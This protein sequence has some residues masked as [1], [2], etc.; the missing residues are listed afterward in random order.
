MKN[1]NKFTVFSVQEVINGLY[2]GNNSAFARANGVSRQAVQ[3]WI[4]D[5][6][7]IGNGYLYSPKREVVVI[8]K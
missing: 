1:P 8:K 4:V 7:M 6:W 5:G 2:K 3:K